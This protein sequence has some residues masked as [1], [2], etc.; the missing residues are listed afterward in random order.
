MLGD[1]TKY[2][3]INTNIDND[4]SKIRKSFATHNETITKRGKYLPQTTSQRLAILMDYQK[5]INPRK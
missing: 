3:L 5:S 1:E 2:E 4:I